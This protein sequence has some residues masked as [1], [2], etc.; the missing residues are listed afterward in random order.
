MSVLRDAS[1]TEEPIVLA[2]RDRGAPAPAS[3]PEDVPEVPA[4]PAE[5]PVTVLRELRKQA[6]DDGYRDGFEIGS[7]E[8]R[9]ALEAQAEE[10]RNAV[11]AVGEAS[12]RMLETHEDA[13]VELAFAAACRVLGEA[14]L[15][16]DGVRGAVRQALRELRSRERLV[17][18]LPPL[19]YRQLTDDAE[20]A[21]ALREE[22]GLDFVADERL[23]PA[24]CLIE[25][26][27]GA[28]DA[29]LEVQL[30][31]LAAALC[32]ARASGSAAP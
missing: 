9:A 16:R 13:L 28:L 25:T 3:L 2:C 31:Q 15:T 4:P 21:A 10:L 20:F 5:D 24:G 6:F 14:V 32:A 18:R 7:A 26:A 29:R 19:A 23:E 17:L 30:Q 27:G 22:H 1:V 8:G 11:R 12:A